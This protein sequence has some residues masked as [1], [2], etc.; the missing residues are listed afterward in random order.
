MIQERQISL[1]VA[2]AAA[3]WTITAIMLF[4][5]TMCAFAASDRHHGMATTLALYSTGLTASA[6]AATLTIRNMIHTLNRRLELAFR[7]GQE[8]ATSVRR[9]R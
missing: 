3:L 1:G 4:A 6:G 5:G 2:F 7:L 9:V 8:S